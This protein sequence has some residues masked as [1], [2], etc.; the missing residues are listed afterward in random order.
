VHERR[1]HLR[2]VAADP[3]K[4]GDPQPRRDGH[5]ARLDAGRAQPLG[6]VAGTDLLEVA[7]AQ[8]D[9]VDPGELGEQDFGTSDAECVDQDM[10][11]DRPLDGHGVSAGSCQQVRRVT[12]GS[13]TRR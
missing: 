10:H 2:E 8:V 4:R 3:P 12:H 6:G 9:A 5:A 1:A 11:A 13:I 7:D